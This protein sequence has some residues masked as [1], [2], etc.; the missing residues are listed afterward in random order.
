MHITLIGMSNIGKTHWAKR[1]VAE[2]GFT[3]VDCD[4]IIEDR[5]GPEL[6]KLG[7]AGIRDVAKWM[8]QPYA[9]QYPETSR[10]FSEWEQITTQEIIEQIRN[11]PKDKK[12]VIDTCGSIIYLQ[13]AM[14]GELRELTRVVYLEASPD[15]VT[16]LFERF[17]AE[18]KPIIWGDIYAPNP[19]EGQDDALKRCY[20]LLLQARDKRYRQMAHVSVPFAAHRAGNADIA[21]ILNGP[22]HDHS[23]LSAAR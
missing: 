10:K 16:Q 2:S 15:H 11:A 1:L 18:P 19:G 5:L 9:P 20:P 21:I 4:Q 13:P 6:T 14:L 7:Y 17:I 3:R 23:P 8:G 12:L 22:S